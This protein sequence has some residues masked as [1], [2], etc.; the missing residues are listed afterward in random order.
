MTHMHAHL[1]VVHFSFSDLSIIELEPLILWVLV[2]GG[3]WR[4]E[5][6]S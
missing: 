3:L 4:D 2:L 1:I 5:T 6:V